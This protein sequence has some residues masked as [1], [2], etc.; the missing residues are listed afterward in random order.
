MPAAFKLCNH[1]WFVRIADISKDYNKNA[2]KKKLG[3]L[4]SVLCL[5][6]SQPLFFGLQL[7]FITLG[8]AFSLTCA[9]LPL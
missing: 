8:G 9:V 7:L 3:V 5:P 2:I 4:V 6:L 1:S